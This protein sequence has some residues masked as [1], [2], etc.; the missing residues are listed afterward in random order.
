MFQHYL[1][2]SLRNL[3]KHLGSSL[4]NIICLSLGLA[5]FMLINAYVRFEKSYD[6]S[7]A[8]AG[9][10]YR[11][12]SRFYSG[13]Q[14]INDWATSTNGYAPAIKDHFPEVQD[15]ARI[16]W[17]DGERVVRNGN[18]KFREEHVCYAD[19]NFFSFFSYP[20]LEG[21][22]NTV[23]KEPNTVVISESSA[24]RYFGHEDPIGKTLDIATI[25]DAYHCV[26]TG[27]FKD[28]PPNS[29]MRF[30]MLLSWSSS[31][32]WMQTTWYL[33]ESYTFLKFYPGTDIHAVERGFPRMAESYKNG[34]A[35]KDLQWAVQLVPLSDIHLNAPK[36]YEV[37][38]K[39]NRRAVQ[40]LL[41]IA[42]FILLIACVNYVNLSTAKGIER[43]KEVGIRKVSGALRSQLLGQ[44]M[45]ESYL[46]GVCA[47][48]IAIIL[49][50]TLGSTLFSALG[51]DMP[52]TALQDMGLW[53]TVLLVF[54]LCILLS[55]L[56]PALI[57]ARLVP[58][59][60]LK[61]RYGFSP[62]GIRFRKA[63]VLFQFVIS[64]L[65]I[66]GTLTVYRQLSYMYGIN[67]GVQINQTLVLK[68]PVKTDGYGMKNIAFKQQLL[69][70]PGV[71]GVTGSG[72]VPG[73]E[74]GEFLA[75]KLDGAPKEEEKTYEM[76]KV[77][78]DFIRLYGLQLI[79]GHAF[80]LSRPSDSTGLVLNESAVKAFGFASPAEA[81][82][83]KI[84]LEVNH[85]RPDLV[86]G[87]VKDY[88][89][90]SLQTEYT[91][92]ILFMDPDYDWIPINYYSVKVSTP[93][94][95]GL[96]DKVSA[97]WN[98]VFPESS[99][100]YFFLDEYYDR[101]YK[102]D[103]QFGRIFGW[104]SCL[105][106]VIASL[107][108]FGLTA[109]TVARRTKEIGVR[110]VLGAAPVRIVRML[111]WEGIALLLYAALL[112]LPLAFWMT[113]QWL[114]GYAFRA[115]L[116]WWQFALPVVLLTLITFCTTAYLTFHAATRSPVKSL[117][118]E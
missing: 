40:F 73:K 32:A 25:G 65:L 37:E 48:L 60:V 118:E 90:Q 81:L 68:A 58:I 107:G 14:L 110:K 111:T 94:V 62:R 15:Y 56:Y 9:R 75:N 52:M 34:P 16:N 64:V 4:I 69:S 2:A 59:K 12:E 76:L 66:A 3:R 30:N 115:P 22:P 83:K 84:W 50:L 103:R 82:G 98:R 74:V 88:H 13:N 57:L 49:M 33:H 26:V 78:Q 80:D 108:L 31:P 46:I 114:N 47:L 36:P 42:F 11:V 61:G 99:V 39:G 8:D 72:A 45:L 23:L 91:P 85:G 106:I 7:H 93:D 54:A 6:K 117:K 10:I 102:A 20:L 1:R 100:D 18:V 38:A 53:I 105:A 97:V 21:D 104:F 92:L 19:S 67:T 17:H 5:A 113:R 96:V 79:A 116:T 77:D 44:Y 41:G 51:L 112:A 24:K 27:V 70:I 95:K 89:Q 87:V 71:T 109:Y 63:L 101:Q 35:L 28:L 86:I 29:T 43:A 55:G